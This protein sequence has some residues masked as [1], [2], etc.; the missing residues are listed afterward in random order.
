MGSKANLYGLMFLLL[1]LQ[2]VVGCDS[3]RKGLFLELGGGGG[4]VAANEKWAVRT[5]NKYYRDQSVLESVFNPTTPGHRYEEIGRTNHSQFVVKGGAIGNFGV[6]YGLS[7]NFIMLYS[8]NGLYGL[9]GR[10]LLSGLFT[11]RVFTKKTAPSLFFDVVIPVSE[12]EFSEISA[13]SIGPGI[14]LGVG[15]EF[16]RHCF[17]KAHFNLGLHGSPDGSDL[18]QA[19]GFYNSDVPNTTMSSV[20]GFTVGFL[21]Y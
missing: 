7:E 12:Y 2:F 9:K 21:L 19:D 3:A 4:V 5:Y 1:V 6:G 20:I 13:S 10:E 14:G 15:Y 18:S 16:T 11:L 8:L 17:V